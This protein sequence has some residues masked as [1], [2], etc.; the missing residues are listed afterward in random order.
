MQNDYTGVAFFL[1]VQRNNE[2]RQY[3][4]RICNKINLE[5][6]TILYLLMHNVIIVIKNSSSLDT[7]Q[8]MK[9]IEK[10]RWKLI[11]FLQLTLVIGHEKRQTYKTAKSFLRFLLL[12]LEH[13]KNL[14]SCG[15]QVHYSHDNLS[16]SYN[17]IIKAVHIR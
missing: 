16:S 2:E 4:Y 6:K 14:F 8:R 1:I 13:K 3:S 5:L 9:W 15:S 10:S 7:R 12:Q 11:H 17:K